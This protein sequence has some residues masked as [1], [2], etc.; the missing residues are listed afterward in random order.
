MRRCLFGE[1]KIANF[2][3]D[4]YISAKSSNKTLNGNSSSAILRINI[5]LIDPLLE[6]TVYTILFKQIDLNLQFCIKREK[7]KTHI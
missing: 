4:E 1:G 5:L 3:P 7:R 6:L 2:N